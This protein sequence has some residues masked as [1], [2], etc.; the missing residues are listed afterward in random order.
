MAGA[1]GESGAIVVALAPS[2]RS[3]RR[4]GRVRTGGRGIAP[5]SD[6]GGGDSEAASNRARAASNDAH[7]YF[8]SPLAI[9]T[10]EQAHVPLLAG[11]NS[12]EQNGQPARG[13]RSR[14][15]RI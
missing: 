1:I 4:T 2:P 11:W 8:P 14:R 5:A 6:D 10:P 3:G 13:M 9:F 15:A 7:G 12:E